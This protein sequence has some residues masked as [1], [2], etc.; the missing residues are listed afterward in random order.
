MRNG[1]ISLSLRFTLRGRLRVAVS[2]LSGSP[3]ALPSAEL[4]FFSKVCTL[5]CSFVNLMSSIQLETRMAQQN[6]DFEAACKAEDRVEDERIVL[7]KVHV[8][9]K[10]VRV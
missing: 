3:H 5:R 2:R 6:P 8:T 9:L 7:S 4:A 1:H 10:Q